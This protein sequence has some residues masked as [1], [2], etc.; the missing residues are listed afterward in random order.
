MQS[1]HSRLLPFALVI[2]AASEQVRV[3]SSGPHGGD[4]LALRFRG[5]NA[6]SCPCHRSRSP[7]R[8]LLRHATALHPARA[9]AAVGLTAGLTKW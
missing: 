9:Q 8:T 7:H 3:E 4:V 5:P 2:V 6:A 1:M